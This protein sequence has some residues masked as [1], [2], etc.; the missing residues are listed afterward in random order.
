MSKKR[1]KRQRKAEQS[2]YHMSR[3]HKKL[4]SK[5]RNLLRRSNEIKAWRLAVISRAGNACRE[6]GSTQFLTAHHIVHFRDICDRFNLTN[7]IRAYKCRALW[8]IT[9]GVCL[10]TRCHEQEHMENN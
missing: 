1:N 2:E 3:R 5:T 9:N 6:C 4:L 10:C 8:D 7:M